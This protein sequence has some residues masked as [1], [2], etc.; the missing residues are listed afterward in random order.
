MALLGVLLLGV[1]GVDWIGDRTAAERAAVRSAREGAAAIAAAPDAAARTAAEDFALGAW[2]AAAAKIADPPRAVL[3]GGEGVG[4]VSARGLRTRSSGLFAGAAFDVGAACWRDGGQRMNCVWGTRVGRSPAGDHE[5]PGTEDDVGGDV[6]L[7]EETPTVCGRVTGS[8]DA[9]DPSS[10]W[11]Q[12]TG[13]SE[14]AR[15]R[16]VRWIV[17]W[18]SGGVVTAES[19]H[20]AAVGSAHEPM[21]AQAVGEGLDAPGVH[22]TLRVAASTG[23]GDPGSA[24]ASLDVIVGEQSQCE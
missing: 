16:L 2:S 20:E 23:P 8:A 14:D 21:P 22:W 17:E 9:D 5:T 10:L 4:G 7:I 6:L 24:W 13:L 11:G 15:D 3:A 12:W 18:S 19:V 1:F